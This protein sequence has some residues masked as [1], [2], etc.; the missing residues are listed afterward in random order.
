M[1]LPV[2]LY[3][4][5]GWS[6]SLETNGRISNADRVDVYKVLIAGGQSVTYSVYVGVYSEALYPYWEQPDLALYVYAGPNFDTLIGVSTSRHGVSS[7][8]YEDVQ[9]NTVGRP[10]QDYYVIVA[11]IDNYLGPVNSREYH[12][13][14]YPGRAPPPP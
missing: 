13:G 4:G 7:P 12:V 11:Y 6:P 3:P 14:A 1:G 9:F 10:T 2:P 8:A 5:T